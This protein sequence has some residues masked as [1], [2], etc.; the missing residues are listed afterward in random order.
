MVK[1]HDFKKSSSSKT[2]KWFSF[3]TKPE[4]KVIVAMSTIASPPTPQDGQICK[5]QFRGNLEEVSFFDISRIVT[6]QA[7]D[8]NY[9]TKIGKGLGSK[10]IFFPY[11]ALLVT[12]FPFDFVSQNFFHITQ[13]APT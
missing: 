7:I 12:L 1:V 4:P 11:M 8:E 13:L 6:F 5:T 9:D 3:S 10:E 2:S